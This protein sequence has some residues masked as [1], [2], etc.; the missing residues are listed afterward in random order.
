MRFAEYPN[1]E[2]G[3]DDWHGGERTQQPDPCYANQTSKNQILEPSY[4]RR[5]EQ[6]LHEIDGLAMSDQS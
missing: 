2:R 4:M 5:S 3:K 1:R 6:N